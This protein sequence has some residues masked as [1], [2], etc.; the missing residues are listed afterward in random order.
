MPQNIPDYIRIAGVL[1]KRAPDSPQVR[2]ALEAR[3]L[4]T[5]LQD[6]A[7]SIVKRMAALAGAAPSA[8]PEIKKFSDS[9][10]NIIKG[11]VGAQPNFPKA[12]QDLQALKPQ[13]GA[14]QQKVANDLAQVL[15]PASVDNMVQ[16]LNSFSA[17]FSAEQA[18]M[19]IPGVQV[20]P[21]AA[22][23]APAP[24]APA[25]APAPTTPPA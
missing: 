2:T 3:S 13:L 20:Q 14:I 8:Q 7:A 19:S 16:L 11:M 22:P 21:P 23:T 9:L 24:A 17:A 4:F 6:T 1:Y 10:T 18:G 25:T 12:Q 15:N 5:P